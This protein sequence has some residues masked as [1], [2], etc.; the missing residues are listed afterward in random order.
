MKCLAP[1]LF[2][3]WA[4]AQLQCHLCFNRRA[5]RDGPRRQRPASEGALSFGSRF[6][7]AASEKA[8]VRGAHWAD[9]W[10][11]GQ[12]LP[13]LLQQVSLKGRRSSGEVYADDIGPFPRKRV[14][15][16]SS[17]RLRMRELPRSEGE[18]IRTILSSLKNKGQPAASSA[19]L[20]TV[21]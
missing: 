15:L 9:P 20:P 6:S 18:N 5:K 16:F 3:Q 21:M 12:D 17:L 8:G 10:G 19:R 1:A 2:L 4:S 7:A 13:S 14:N 11:A